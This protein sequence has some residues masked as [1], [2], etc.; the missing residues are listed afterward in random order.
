MQRLAILDGFRGFF[1]LF[2][3]VAHYDGLIGS[4]LGKLHH[5]HFGWVEDA[6]G[7]VFISGLVVGIVYGRKFLKV[8]TA[9]A[10]AG[11]ILSRIGTIYLHQVV[12]VFLLLVA[13]LLLGRFAAPEFESYIVAPGTFVVSS[14]LLVSASDH[15]GILFLALTPLA[16]SVLKRDLLVPYFAAIGLC[17]MA[18]QTGLFGWAFYQLEVA[19]NG[20][21][22]P[23]ELG[24]YFNMLGWQV[25][26]F[27][28]LF[29]GFRMAQR[30]LD[31]GF[32]KAP[33]VRT[34]WFM[35]L[36]AFLLL[37]FYD[38]AVH[39]RLLG[40]TY[41]STIFSRWPRSVLA[42]IYVVAFAVD[43]FLVVWL[44][45]V[46]RDDRAAWIRG[47]AG[48]LGWL[49]SRRPL[50]MLGQ[51]SLHVFSFHIIVFYALAVIVPLL[52]PSPTGRALLLIVSVGSLYVAAWGHA[53]WQTR[54]EARSAV[55]RAAG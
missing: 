18:A 23:V 14:L 39:L 47:L 30:R 26:F 51:H 29:V 45:Q 33:Q 55:T 9:R 32:L 8:P 49:F 12:L 1:L 37:G 27:G 17:W 4:W 42:P 5:Q 24:L 22:V 46:G 15:M 44:L 16:L 36:G 10:I 40:E 34:A 11:P 54:S 19:M 50:V 31:L 20:R 35:A 13:A 43:L 38:L 48:A 6:Q 25:L 41:S 52:E 53:W 7:F 3:A 21:G 28:G 2:M